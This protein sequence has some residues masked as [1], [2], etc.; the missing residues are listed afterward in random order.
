MK[1]GGLRRQTLRMLNLG[2]EVVPGGE[3]PVMTFCGG[4]IW[5]GQPPE[6]VTV[7]TNNPSIISVYSISLITD[8]TPCEEFVPPLLK[9][10][11]GDASLLAPQNSVDQTPINEVNSP[12][13]K[14][15]SVLVERIEIARIASL[16]SNSLQLHHE[17][18]SLNIQN[19]L[20]T[21]QASWS[22]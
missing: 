5:I 4:E 8:N 22:C 15:Y 21:V 18:K 6:G 7:I 12:L 9:P 11:P 2:S 1:L 13:L 16:N 3:A 14:S 10:I 19:V 17:I 20:H